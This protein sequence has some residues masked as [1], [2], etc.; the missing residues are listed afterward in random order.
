MATFDSLDDAVQRIV[1]PLQLGFAYVL[2]RAMVTIRSDNSDSDM[3]EDARLHVYSGTSESDENT[4]ELEYPMGTVVM[5]RP[6]L[7]DTS[8]YMFGAGQNSVFQTGNDTVGG[9]NPLS[10][11]SSVIYGGVG[12]SPF[13]EVWSRDGGGGPWTISYLF[14]WLI[15]NIEQAQY[16]GIYWNLPTRQ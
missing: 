2:R 6:T 5:A 14:E 11:P 12:A 7:R 4:V 10:A 3:W 15:F 9:M 1:L 13:F 8:S 16:S